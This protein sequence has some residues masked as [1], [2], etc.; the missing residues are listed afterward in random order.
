MCN[1][2]SRFRP[3]EW[4]C[5]AFPDGI[6]GALDLGGADHRLPLRG[7]HGIL[8]RP[9]DAAARA[10]VDD[11][12]GPEPQKYEGPMTIEDVSAE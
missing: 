9:R 5:D 12:W 7:D 6:P 4:A 11:L 1:Y 3:E 8:F 2:C 10:T